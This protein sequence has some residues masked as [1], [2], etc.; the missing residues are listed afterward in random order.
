MQ[1]FCW[2]IIQTE[3][4]VEQRETKIHYCCQSERHSRALRSSS[5]S[6]IKTLRC[7]C[8]LWYLE[9]QRI[10]RLKYST[11][12]PGCSELLETVT[13]GT[14]PQVLTGITYKSSQLKSLQITY[15]RVSF[16]VCRGHSVVHRSEFDPDNIDIRDTMRETFTAHTH[17][18]FVCTRVYCIEPSSNCELEWIHP[19]VA[20]GDKVCFMKFMLLRR[21]TLLV[22][23]HKNMLQHPL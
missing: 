2:S 12:S 1:W 23:L 20:Y 17:S 6:T 14:L 8:C 5:E 9:L 7:A 10:H 3:S 19:G 16:V 18:N 22:F 21:F 4:L 11:D 15:L 13:V